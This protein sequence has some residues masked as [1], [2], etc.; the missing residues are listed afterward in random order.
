MLDFGLITDLPDLGAI[1]DAWDELAVANR[2]PLMA[3]ACVMAWWR[4]MA[5]PSAQ[6]RA[7]AVH[8]DG[9]LIGLAPFYADLDKP[10]GRVDYRLP[11]IQLA[12]RLAPLALDGTRARRGNGDRK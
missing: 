2:L 10:R 7:L 8:D 4:H 1:E 6:L 12:A 3:P 9:A 5:P 11:G